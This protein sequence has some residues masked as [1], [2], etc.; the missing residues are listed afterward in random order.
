MFIIF[1]FKMNCT[2]AESLSPLLSVKF[3]IF[4]NLKIIHIKI[5]FKY[6]QFYN[7]IPTYTNTFSNYF[8][9]WF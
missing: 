1:N 5:K 7:F 4:F 2:S 8:N 3:K 9:I 6:N